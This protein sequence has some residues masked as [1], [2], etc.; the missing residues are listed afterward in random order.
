MEHWVK[1]YRGDLG[2]AL[3]DTTTTPKFLEVF[4][5]YYAR[6]FDGARQDSGDPKAIGDRGDAIGL[7]QIHRSYWTD[8]V[9][10]DKTL[11]GTYKDCFDPDYARRVVCAYLHR[12][13]S[14]NSDIEQL[15]RIHNGGCN[16]L[17]K[18]HSQKKSE[19]KA[20]NNTT[21]Y[22]NKIKKEL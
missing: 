10:Y 18:Q 19:V 14:N 13:G 20:W 7:Y 21:K 6:L 2:I 8:A 22:W 9:N 12:Y 5:S 4:D 15:A 16:I 17:K 3:T 1:E 11:G